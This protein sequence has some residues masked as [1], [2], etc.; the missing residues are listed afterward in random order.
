LIRFI[1]GSLFSIP[2]FAGA[3]CAFRH[4]QGRVKELL[5]GV[6]QNCQLNILKAYRS[7]EM[8]A[9]P[10]IDANTKLLTNLNRTFHSQGCPNPAESWCNAQTYL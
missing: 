10:D 5:D 1:S 3:S 7:H 8:P 9:Y 2:A 6:I 4:S